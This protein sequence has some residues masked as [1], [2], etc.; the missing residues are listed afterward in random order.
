M[1]T[2]FNTPRFESPK[3]EGMAKDILSGA[4]EKSENAITSVSEGVNQLVAW[5]KKNPLQAAAIGAGL[6]FVVGAL[7]RKIAARD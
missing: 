1:T 4:K 7:F 3:S 2:E 6:G 5:S